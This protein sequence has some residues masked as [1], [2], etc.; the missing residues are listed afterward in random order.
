MLGLAWDPHKALA[1]PDGA[2]H[3]ALFLGALGALLLVWTA[4]SAWRTS[5]TLDRGTQTWAQI[6]KAERTTGWVG[7]RNRKIALRWTDMNAQERTTSLTEVSP[8]FWNELVRDGKVV[9]ARIR[10][11]YLDDYPSAPPLMIDDKG[12]SDWRVVHGVMVVLSLLF[13]VGSIRAIRKARTLA[14]QGARRS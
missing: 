12:W 4:Y 6:T 2:R 1:T 13:F 11:K 3:V 8:E 7:T 9:V 14:A 10:I 5:A